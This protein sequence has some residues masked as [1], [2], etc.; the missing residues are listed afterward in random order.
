MIDRRQFIGAGTCAVLLTSGAEARP[1]LPIEAAAPG[2]SPALA[3]ALL[4]FPFI[5]H[6]RGKTLFVIT[7]KTCVHCQRMARDFPAPPEG[8]QFVYVVCP[9]K[10]TTRRALVEVYRRRTPEAFA[11]FMRGDFDDGPPLAPAESEFFND[12]V[13]QWTG[14]KDAM[15]RAGIRFITPT[16]LFGSPD[17]LHYMR[18][19]RRETIEELSRLASRRRG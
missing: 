8:L 16:L 19:Y 10:G 15:S 11:A 7:A 17:Q 18:G 5:A 2:T 1:E 13:I 3:R 9:T 4:A 6:G 12:R 14:L